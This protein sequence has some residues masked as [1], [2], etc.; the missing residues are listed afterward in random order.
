MQTASNQSYDN[1]R[2]RGWKWLGVQPFI[3]M[4]TAPGRCLRDYWRSR[5]MFRRPFWTLAVVCYRGAPRLVKLELRAGGVLWI[6]AGTVD[7]AVVRTVFLLDEYGTEALPPEPLDCVV[8]VGAHIGSFV[9]KIAPLAAHIL[10]IEPMADN[11]EI[12][13]RNLTGLTVGRVDLIPA[14]ISDHAGKMRLFQGRNTASHS[15]FPGDGTTTQES[16]EVECLRLPDVLNQKQIAHVDF[17]KVDCEGAEYGIL[18]SLQAWGLERIDRIVM[19]YHPVK[20][21]ASAIT[22]IAGAEECLRRAG[23]AVRRVPEKKKPGF[24]VIHAVRGVLE[25]S[26]GLVR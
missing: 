20:E 24:G 4:L 3:R 8:D 18:S 9:V 5:R 14:A 17:L 6:R 26:P 22:S 12:F 16:C 1:E 21:L 11:L 7:V 19:E 10:A 2:T 25:K 13:R 23:F 15:A